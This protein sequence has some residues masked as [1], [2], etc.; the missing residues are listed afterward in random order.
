MGT[1]DQP[2]TGRP[3]PR[4][5]RPAAGGAHA[6]PLRR[7]AGAAATPAPPLAPDDILKTIDRLAELRRKEV[8]TEEEFSAKKGELLARL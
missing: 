8:L 6:P 7:P 1:T 3:P 5:R 4:P 2:R